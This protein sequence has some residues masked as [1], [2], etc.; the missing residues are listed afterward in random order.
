MTE[1][2]LRLSAPAAVM[3]ED[4][5]DT[6]VIFP[7]RFL[8]RMDKQGLGGCLF[9]DRRLQSECTGA[10]FAL[11]RPDG[12]LVKIFFAGAQFGCGS[13]RE[14]AVWALVDFGIRAVIAPSFGEIFASNAARNGLAAIPLDREQVEALAVKSRAGDVTIDLFTKTIVTADGTSIAF[15]L[16]ESDRQALINGWDEIDML[17]TAHAAQIERFELAYRERVPWLF[18]GPAEF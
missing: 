12:K 15:N 18:T 13:S 5:I 7:A 16:A 8:L 4:A 11:D 10:A 9:A 17:H 1:P 3:L 6:D 2:L 14:H